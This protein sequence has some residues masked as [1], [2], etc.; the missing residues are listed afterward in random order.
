MIAANSL[1]WIKIINEKYEQAKNLEWIICIQLADKNMNK[2]FFQFHFTYN[3]KKSSQNASL[4]RQWTVLWMVWT[5]ESI[6]N[7]NFRFGIQA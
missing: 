4:C 6:Q 2:Q 5:F 3:A 1:R 7:L